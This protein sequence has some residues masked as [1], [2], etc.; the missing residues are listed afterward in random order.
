MKKAKCNMDCL[1]CIHPKCINNSNTLTLEEYAS[2]RERDQEFEKAEAEVDYGVGSRQN[3]K[4]YDVKYFKTHRKEHL[5]RCAEYRENN[6]EKRKETTK[7]YRD[8]NRDAI[9]ERARKF[10]EDNLEEM[11]LRKRLYYQEH[12]EEINRKR[13]ERSKQKNEDNKRESADVA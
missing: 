11:R 6:P 4:P 9:N 8:N 10:Y 3:R 5:K 13:R 12:K 1:N 2:I 7:N